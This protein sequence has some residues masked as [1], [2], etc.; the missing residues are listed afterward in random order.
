MKLTFKYF[1]RKGAHTKSEMMD[2][3]SKAQF[4]NYDINEDRITLSTCLQKNL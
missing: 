1:L 4:K 2:L 3:I